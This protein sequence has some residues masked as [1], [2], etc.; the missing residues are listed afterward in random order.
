[1]DRN[2]FYVAYSGNIGFT[3]NIELLIDVA[4]RIKNDK[5]IQFI[6]IGEGVYKEELKKQIKKNNIN[7]I[8]LIPFQ[9]YDRISEV[10][11]IGDCGL[12]ISK[13]GIAINSVPSKTWSYMAAE[14]PVLTSFDLNSELVSIITE[15]DCGISVKPNSCDD[16]IRAIYSLKNGG[17]VSGING[18]KYID[19]YLSRE[20]GTKKYIDVIKSVVEKCQK[21]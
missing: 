10:F 2:C 4:Q 9:P 11:S 5:K 3:Q 16:L 7:N 20:V 6:L 13:P 21:I 12:I 18:R 1:M 19:K 15:N 8:R 17:G 14:R